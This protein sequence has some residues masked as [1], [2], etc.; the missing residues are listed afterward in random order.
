MNTWTAVTSITRA[1]TAPTNATGHFVERIAN[2]VKLPSGS[3]TW[4]MHWEIMLVGPEPPQSVEAT[5]R[6]LFPGLTVSK[7]SKNQ[8]TR[9][10]CK[11]AAGIH[12]Q[13]KIPRIEILAKLMRFAHKDSRNGNGMRGNRNEYANAPIVMES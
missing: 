7:Q 5:R 1:P 8:S 9:R 6:K 10:T 2:M 4:Q 11:L 13:A 12:G 3:H